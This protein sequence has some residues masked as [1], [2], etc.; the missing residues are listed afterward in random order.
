MHTHF[1]AVIGLY[2]LL[3]NALALPQGED[4][5][6]AEAARI[7]K[8]VVLT[9]TQALEKTTGAPLPASSTDS[10][11][12]PSDPAAIRCPDPMK[13]CIISG[14]PK[15]P[16]KP[17]TPSI[18]PSTIASATTKSSHGPAP[19]PAPASP[20]E[21]A[22]TTC[23]HAMSHNMPG[24]SAPATPPTASPP[25]HNSPSPAPGTSSMPHPALGNTTPSTPK[26][27]NARHQTAYASTRRTHRFVA[28]ANDGAGAKQMDN[29]YAYD[30][31]ECI[32]CPKGK[33]L[34][35]ID[36]THYGFCDEGCV[37]VRAVLSGAKCEDGRIYQ[38]GVDV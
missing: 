1:T 7:T 38:D 21:S 32:T 16:R 23:S 19:A 5:G 26:D 24:H 10:M 20:P 25:T 37:E 4:A 30:S 35:C 6:T 2:T 3:A 33:D 17:N 22:I 34:I 28:R 27:N 18:T 14:I 8:T 13:P 12:V 31:K 36:G 9:V 29:V 15:W 11:Q